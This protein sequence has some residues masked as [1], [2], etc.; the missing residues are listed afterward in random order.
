[1]NLEFHS[2]FERCDKR[3][4]IIPLE[5]NPSIYSY[6]SLNKQT[7]QK[8]KFSDSLQY[9][10]KKISKKNQILKSYFEVP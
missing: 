2:D 8:R 10:G 9:G 4:E 1:M 3:Y 5:S 7:N 6:Y